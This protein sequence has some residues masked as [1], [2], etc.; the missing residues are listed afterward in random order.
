MVNIYYTY[1]I[2][3]LTSNGAYIIY[4][5]IYKQVANNINITLGSYYASLKNTINVESLSN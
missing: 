4:L 1:F 5:F 3:L 2:L